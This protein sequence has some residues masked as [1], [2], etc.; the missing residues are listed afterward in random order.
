MHPH[1]LDVRVH[2]TSRSRLTFESGHPGVGT[3]IA[4]G[5]LLSP[6]GTRYEIREGVPRMVLGWCR[7]AGLDVEHL[8]VIESGISVCASRPR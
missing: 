6:D 7:D 4:S 3:E 5:A 1:L 8:N 2:P